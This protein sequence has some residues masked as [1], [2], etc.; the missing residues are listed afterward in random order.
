MPVDVSDFDRQEQNADN[1]VDDFEFRRLSAETERME[2]INRDAV[3][4]R[5]HRIWALVICMVVMAIML[6]LLTIVVHETLL[7]GIRDHSAH[8]PASFLLAAYV[9]P[10]TSMTVV[11]VAFLLGVFRAYR[12]VDE[13]RAVSGVVESARAGIGA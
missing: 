13:S 9:S 8:L 11:T 12:D 4:R 7:E 2:N 1:R 3:Q 6:A 10:I 5:R